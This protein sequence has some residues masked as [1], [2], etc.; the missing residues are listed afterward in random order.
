MI[1]LSFSS[2]DIPTHGE[3]ST[4]YTNWIK[5]TSYIFWEG[6]LAIL[7]SFSKDFSM[8]IIYNRSWVPSTHTVNHSFNIS[9]ERKRKKLKFYLILWFIL[10]NNHWNLPLNIH[11]FSIPKSKILNYIFSNST[12]KNISEIL[13]LPW[14][15]KSQI[16]QEHLHL[17]QIMFNNFYR[18]APYIYIQ[19]LFFIFFTLYIKTLGLYILTRY[20]VG[21]MNVIYL[22]WKP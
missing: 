7:H 13:A 20:H 14:P 1:Y 9:D 6:S 4:C 19:T 8:K 16:R 22:K 5:K 3:D 18:L 11:N 10:T 2:L 12:G 17:P 21:N 15:P